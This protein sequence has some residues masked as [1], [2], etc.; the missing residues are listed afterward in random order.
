MCAPESH[1]ALEIR[2]DYAADRS[3]DCC[4]QKQSNDE[5]C[6]KHRKFRVSKGHDALPEPAVSLTCRHARAAVR[7][8]CT[9]RSVIFT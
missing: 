6:D 5:S 3:R 1:R 7:A 4:T 9:V 8:Y 2:S